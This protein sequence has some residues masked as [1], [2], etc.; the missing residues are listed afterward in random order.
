[1]NYDSVFR[2]IYSFV[3]FFPQNV[4]QYGDYMISVFSFRFYGNN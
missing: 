1:M 3:Q 4:K 2:K